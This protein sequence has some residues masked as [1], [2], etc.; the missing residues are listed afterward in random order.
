[1]KTELVRNQGKDRDTE[2]RPVVGLSR[3]PTAV[4]NL[5][6]PHGLDVHVIRPK[7]AAQAFFGAA[8]ILFPLTLTSCTV[9]PDYV[10]P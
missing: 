2:L 10:R 5:H 7:Q 9:G 6:N 8:L 1:M 4:G 3:R